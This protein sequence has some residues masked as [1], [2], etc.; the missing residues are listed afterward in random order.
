VTA[1]TF[2]SFSATA[3][4][5][6]GGLSDNVRGRAC[7]ETDLGRRNE[8]EEETETLNSLEFLQSVYRDDSQPLGV[9]MRC[10]V[11][12]LQYERP[13]LTAVG[14]AVLDEQTFGDLLD[15]AI[16]RVERAKRPPP[17]MIDVT[18]HPAGEL[19]GPMARMK[20]RV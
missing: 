16:A 7:H 5:R 13:K 9:R 4:R 10:A 17:K 19:K 12:A 11:E 8:G 15:K 18:P 14:S 3:C 20:R 6:A 1:I 2:W